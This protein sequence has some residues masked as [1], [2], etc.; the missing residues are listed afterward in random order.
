MDIQST[1]FIRDDYWPSQNELDEINKRIDN[2]ESDLALNTA[3]L[4]LSINNVSDNLNAYKDEQADTSISN[5]IIVNDINANY[6]KGK[7]GNFQNISSDNIVTNNLQ[8]VKP[9]TGATLTDSTV[10]NPHIT[11]GIIENVSITNVN[12][13]QFVELNDVNVKNLNILDSL[14]VDDIYSSNVNSVNVN[15]DFGNIKNIKS[16]DIDIV[17]ASIDNASIHSADIISLDVTSSVIGNIVSDNIVANNIDVLNIQVEELTVNELSAPVNAF[18]EGLAFNTMNGSG[19]NALGVN[20]DIISANRIITSKSEFNDVNISNAIIDSLQANNASFEN[21]K[22]NINEEPVQASSLLGYDETGRIIPVGT[23]TYTPVLP[24]NAD[25][26]LTDQFGTAFAGQADTV[27]TEGSSNLVT[28]GA[29]HNIVSDVNNNI[30]NDIS[31]IINDINN[32]FNI[33]NNNIYDSIANNNADATLKAY[34]M[35]NIPHAGD[36]NWPYNGITPTG[37][38]YFTS[39]F[40]LISELDNVSFDKNTLTTFGTKDGD[41]YAIGIGNYFMAHGTD[42]TQVDGINN[43]IITKDQQCSKPFFEID[44][45]FKANGY[46]I[47]GKD[48]YIEAFKPGFGFNILMTKT[49]HTPAGSFEALDNYANYSIIPS[50]CGTSSFSSLD[51]LK[52]DIAFNTSKWEPIMN[53]TTWTI[54]NIVV[55]DFKVLDGSLF[56][57][58]GQVVVNNVDTLKCNFVSKSDAFFDINI[59]KISSYFNVV[60]GKGTSL[61]LELN[62]TPLKRVEFS[63]AE[64]AQDN[65]HFNDHDIYINGFNCINMD[66]ANNSNNCYFIN[67][68]SGQIM[69][70]VNIYLR[71]TNFVDT[72]DMALY[73]LF[74]NLPTGQINIHIPSTFDDSTTFYRWCNAAN[75]A[76]MVYNDL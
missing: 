57:N 71:P 22:L 21:V 54:N 26:I 30:N 69:N 15:A 40:K 34:M 51:R 29:V 45:S 6:A 64:D 52:G 61:H 43:I 58:N 13:G 55:N 36:E 27:V 3:S 48:V 11:G 65:T 49:L 8:V 16:N 44:A 68:Y 10:I 28:S 41:G 4:Q 38:L 50:F 2:V 46:G 53:V 31:N 47:N 59:N 5:N 66:S 67:S 62:E 24:N 70:N 60:I 14:Q 75:P 17:N 37:N 1:P 56:T 39:N 23:P 19:I 7:Y 74:R 18:I 73:T 9:I 76:I 32:G 25:Y 42:E 33:I 35:N 20:A 63:A 72:P 12:L